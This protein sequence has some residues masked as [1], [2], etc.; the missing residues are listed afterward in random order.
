MEERVPAPVVLVRR[1]S[2]RPLARWLFALLA[3]AGA[4]AGLVRRATGTCAATARAA[5]PGTDRAGFR[6]HAR[7]SSQHPRVPGDESSSLPLATATSCGATVALPVAPPVSAATAVA[8]GDSLGEPER[9][10]SSVA[11]AVPLP[12]PRSS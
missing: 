12:P 10:L 1:L 5:A 7:E 4:Q 9:V 2:R 3:F 6:H 8:G 11:R